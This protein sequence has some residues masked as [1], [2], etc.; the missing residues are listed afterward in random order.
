VQRRLTRLGFEYQDHGTF[1]ES[2]RAAISRCRRSPA[3]FERFLNAGQHKALTDAA[4]QAA[5]PTARTVAALETYPLFAWWRR[6]I[7]AI[8]GVARGWG[9]R[10][11]V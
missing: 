7:G 10:C 11:V 3:T 1:D 9:A 8:G 5:K 4:K 2:T 6:S